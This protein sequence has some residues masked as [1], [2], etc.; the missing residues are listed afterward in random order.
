MT[1]NTELHRFVEVDEG[2]FIAYEQT[3]VD[4]T[5]AAQL[6]QALPTAS[7]LVVTRYNCSDSARNIPK[8]TRLAEHLPGWEWLVY[9]D[10]PDVRMRLNV[11]KVPTIIV[12]QNSTELGRIVENP[13]SGDLLY[14]LLA[15]AQK[16]S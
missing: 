12:R 9:S 1:L 16:A 6:A 4:E 13:A 2:Y 10:S 15:I 7:V 14:D 8:M 3:Q 5:L 11:E